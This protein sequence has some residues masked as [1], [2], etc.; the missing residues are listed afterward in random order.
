MLA[1]ASIDTLWV[2]GRATR[3]GMLYGGLAGVAVGTVL[4]A[5][6]GSICPGRERTE[7]CAR[8]T[9][10][11]A[12]FGL[13]IGAMAGGLL[14][15]NNPDWQRLHPRGRSRKLSVMSPAVSLF[16]PGDS[17]VPDARALA[18]ARV[19]SGRVVR[20]EFADRPDLLGYMTGGGARHATLV[21]VGTAPPETVISLASLNAVWERA[22]ASHTGSVIGAIAGVT[23]GAFVGVEA[24][25]A[26]GCSRSST[27]LANGILGGLAGW[28]LGGR[29]GSLVPKWRRRF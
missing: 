22:T 15:S 2:R 1:L 6:S 11:S 13:A 26:R 4:G 28:L 17:S 19:R 24:T 16:A 9:L 7:P 10:S 29:V 21:P 14:G 25:C 23:A 12:V 3:Q 5:T 18:L 8:G 20:L 27:M